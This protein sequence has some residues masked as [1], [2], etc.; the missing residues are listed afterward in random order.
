MT[1]ATNF[2]ELYAGKGILDTYMVAEKITRY[3]TQDLIQLSGLSES[4]LTP[5]VILDLACGTG[6]VSDAL[7]DMLNFQPKGNWELTCGDISTELTGHVKQKIL[8][9]GWENSIAKVVD[10]QNTELP[11]GHYTHVFAALAFTSFPD[12]YAAMKEVMRILQPGGTLTIS[13]WQRTEWLAV[14]EA[15]VA[16]IPADLPFPTTKEFMSC[17][18]PGWD[19]EDYV[20]SRFEEAG[21]HSVQVTTI[22]KQF[23]TSVED[24][25]KIAQPVIPIIV[26]KWWNQEQRDKYEN[27]ILPALQ[28]HLNETYGENGLVPQEWTA[29]FATGQKGS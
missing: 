21:F 22:S 27:D 13:T 11:T 1:R 4:S 14:V 28:R 8:E 9:R 18:N 10:A 17:M 16:I 20:H 12:T 7:H 3:Y 15:A 5:L 29:V 2:T 24:L 26:S 25:Y 23:E 19:S 6:V